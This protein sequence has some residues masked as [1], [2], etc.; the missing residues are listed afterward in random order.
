MGINEEKTP[1]TSEV[2]SENGP[3]LLDVCA[4]NSCC[5]LV[6]RHVSNINLLHLTLERIM[7]TNET[8][9]KLS[10]D[11]INQI[12]HDIQFPGGSEY[13]DFFSALGVN[14]Y[15]SNPG[16]IMP[17]AIENRMCIDFERRGVSVFSN[18]KLL[19]SCYVSYSHNNT[20][21]CRAI[22]IIYIL[23]NQGE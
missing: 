6:N 20:G 5:S 11:E 22:C 18:N 3:T 2:Q 14:P 12:V 8:L 1:Q 23:M 17:I 9:T 16:V 21:Y 19:A 7:H 15:C 13:D 10:D 4:S